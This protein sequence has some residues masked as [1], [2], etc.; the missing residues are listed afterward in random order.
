MNRPH[1]SDQRVHSPIGINLAKSI[2]VKSGKKQKQNRRSPVQDGC[3]QV[4]PLEINRLARGK[5]LVDLRSSA[6]CAF[7]VPADCGGPVDFLVRIVKSP[8]CSAFAMAGPLVWPHA[9]AL[10]KINTF[11][12]K[13]TT[14]PR[15]ITLRSSR[16][17]KRKERNSAN[18]P[19]EN[20]PAKPINGYGLAVLGSS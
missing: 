3:L 18:K 6:D 1:R 9:T 13:A 12:D 8:D 15:V 7:V 14:R 4:S 10:A 16:Y 5:G 20:M 19:S 11:T 17:D 2:R